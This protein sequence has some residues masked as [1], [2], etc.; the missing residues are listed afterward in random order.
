[1]DYFLGNHFTFHLDTVF[2]PGNSYSGCI[3]R[4]R[5]LLLNKYSL[6]SP[7]LFSFIIHFTFQIWGFQIE[8]HY[9]VWKDEIQIFLNDCSSLLYFK[10][11]VTTLHILMITII[12]LCFIKEFSCDRPWKYAL[13]GKTYLLLKDLWPSVP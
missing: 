3:L 4:S 5:T 2:H 7:S 13:G 9:K 6:S 11:K 1:M 8:M 12:I 10:A